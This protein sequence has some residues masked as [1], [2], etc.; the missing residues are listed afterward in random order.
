MMKVIQK[1]LGDLGWSDFI[2][3]WVNIYEGDESDFTPIHTHGGDLSSVMILKLPEDS[4]GQNEYEN[5]KN[6]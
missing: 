5:D 6:E 1:E 4:E 2:D 3:A